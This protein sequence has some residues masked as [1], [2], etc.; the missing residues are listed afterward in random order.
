MTQFLKF[1]PSRVLG[2][3]AVESVSFFPDRIELHSAN[4]VVTHRFVDIARWP[5][6]VWLWK[7]LYRLGVR[8]RSLA[9]GDRDWF[10]NPSDMYFE[11]YTQLRL[12]VY[13]PNDEVKQPY[14]SSYFARIQNVLREGG[15]YTNDLG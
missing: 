2:A 1:A 12:R 15:F 10:H 9:V 8:P 5:S 6:P 13:M 7:L 11:F 4:E 3:S 14:D